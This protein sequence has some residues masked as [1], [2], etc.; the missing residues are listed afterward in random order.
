LFDL[1]IKYLLNCKN[2]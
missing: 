2:W 1:K